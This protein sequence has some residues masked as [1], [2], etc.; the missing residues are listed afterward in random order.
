[1]KYIILALVEVMFFLKNKAVIGRDLKQIQNGIIPM[2]TL[3]K[4]YYSY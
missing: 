4:L 1:M 2:L 3:I